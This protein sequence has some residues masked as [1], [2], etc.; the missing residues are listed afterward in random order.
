MCLQGAD[1]LPLQAKLER[2]QEQVGGMAGDQRGDY[3]AWIARCQAS[4]LVRNDAASGRWIPDARSGN[5]VCVVGAATGEKKQEGYGLAELEASVEELR[6][7]LS[8]LA[9]LRRA[10][11]AGA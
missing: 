9:R 1:H 5:V 10:G 8:E 6:D 2:L 7:L 3:Q 4:P 11:V